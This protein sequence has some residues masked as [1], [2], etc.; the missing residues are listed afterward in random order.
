MSTN[1]TSQRSEFVLPTNRAV[2]ATN[3]ADNL[4]DE[5]CTYLCGNSLGAL[6]K[7][8]EAL[9]LD[10]LRV[11]GS[12]AVEG[13][14]AHPHGRPWKDMTD[15]VNPLLAELVGA[16]SHEVACMGGLTNNLHLMMS[17]FY[18]PTATRYKI[19]C[20]ARAFSSD[21]YAFASQAAVHGLDPK[22]AVVA[23]SPRTNEYNLRE[24]DIL[25]AIEREGSSIAL[26]LF[27]G[28]QY[29]TGQWFAMENITRA[30]KDKGC[31]CGWDLAHGIGNVPMALHDWNVDFAVWCSYKYLN[32]GPG[33]IAG[34]FVHEK[35]ADSEKPKSVLH[36][37][38][39]SV[40]S[41]C[42]FI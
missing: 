38:F 11:W 2:K 8:A 16:K 42:F 25:A 39:C 28:V 21:Q 12:C 26:L 30:A 13:H 27:P 4:L 19:L 1:S 31:I 5:P 32:A 17:T 9:V 15:H 29:Y 24:E 7:R 18:R 34:L 6:P 36:P 23:L 20:E 3:V 22:T 37:L 14:F 10:E 33:A 35:W 40:Q 41:P